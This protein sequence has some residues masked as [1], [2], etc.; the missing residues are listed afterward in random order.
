[1]SFDRGNN[2]LQHEK[3]KLTALF[4]PKKK[5]GKNLKFCTSQKHDF[6]DIDDHSDR[7]DIRILLKLGI[8]HL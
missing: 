4:T 7:T 5:I 8:Y 6:L 2:A 1:M 3:I